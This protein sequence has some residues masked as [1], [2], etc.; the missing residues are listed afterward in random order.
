MRCREKEKGSIMVEATIYMPLV[1]CTALAL[2]YLA[3]F[4]MQEHLM[5][6]EAQRVAAITARE[7][8][9]SGYEKFGMGDDNE[10]EFSWGEGNYPQE[11]EITQYYVGHH[12][13]I[14]E[15][16]REVSGFLSITFGNPASRYQTRF[17]DAAREAA[18][19]SIGD[20]SNPEIK[21]DKS[22]LGTYV[23]V[24][25]KHSLPTPG[26]LRYL[27]IDDELEMRS[28]AYTYSGNPAAFVRNVDLAVDLTSYVLE[29]F[30]V[31][32]DVDA[33]MAKTQNVLDKI[34]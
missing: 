5:M 14:K 32:D 19:V 1:I 8:A 31:K 9:Y 18:L 30:G 15:L 7:I 33:F 2:I 6:Y 12:S 10:I 27:G 24:T 34:L 22:L 11:S 16:Y 4:N 17:A 25:F 29:K 26:V 20:I 28:V 13:S 23:T 3:L 21:I